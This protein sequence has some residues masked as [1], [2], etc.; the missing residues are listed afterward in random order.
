MKSPAPYFRAFDG[1]WYVQLRVDGKRKQI[2][3]AKGKDCE[4]LAMQEWHKFCAALPV[5]QPVAAGS[6]LALL[7]LFLD[8][9]KTEASEGT[10]SWYRNYFKSFKAW[11]V[12]NKLEGLELEAFTPAHVTSWLK[13]QTTWSKST[14]NGAV[15]AMRRAFRWLDDEGH[16]ERYPLKGLKAPPRGRRE[17]I[18]SPEKFQ[19]ILAAVKDQQFNDF[20]C[21]LY[22]T[23]CRPQ[24]ACQAEARHFQ[25]AMQR[26]VFPASESKGKEYPRVIYLN[27]IALAIV[28]RLCKKYPQGKILRNRRGRPWNRNTVR[29]RFR[30]LRGK[31]G[32]FCAYHLRHTFATEALQNLD[33]FTVSVLM[34][35]AD[36]STLARQ[37]QHLAKAP[38][39]LQQAIN[40]ARGA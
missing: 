6:V 15:R 37:Y 19:E 38:G 39:F 32:H 5:E 33:A 9:Y 27:N 7:D 14:K 4:E 24:E 23:G 34:G 3:L 36:V 31:V 8:H 2:K 1:W 28:D 22:A 29:C 35:H 30:R 12:K 21:F 40:R 17:T 25:P 18:I 11:L 16:I 10:Y 20:L 13:G 26:L